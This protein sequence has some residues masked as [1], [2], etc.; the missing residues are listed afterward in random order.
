[1][2]STPYRVE[3]PEWFRQLASGQHQVFQSSADRMRFVIDLARRN[4]REGTGGPFGAAIFEHESGRLIAPGVN[5]VTASRCSVF[6]AEII[7]IIFAQ[8]ALSSYDLSRAGLPECTLVTSTEPCAMCM[9]AV[10]WSGVR[11]LVCGARDEDARAAGFDE[12]LKPER[13]KAGL[14]SRGIRVFTDVL[15]AEAAEVLK[16]YAAGGGII[17]NSAAAQK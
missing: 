11:S 7:A 2:I 6:H 5:I 12:G 1:M 9:G 3:L 15:R 14:E 10:H 16:E 4:I 17:Y 8:R 13:W